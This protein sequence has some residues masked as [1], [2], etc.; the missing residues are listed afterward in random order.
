MA[1]FWD[2]L[3]SA[4][5]LGAYKTGPSTPAGAPLRQTVGGRA[6]QAATEVMS[7]VR[8]DVNRQ[9]MEALGRSDIAYAQRGTYRSG[10]ALEARQRLEEQA[11]R[12]I[13]AES[14]RT[15]LQRLGLVTQ[16]DLANMQLQASQQGQEAAM[17]GTIF[18]AAAPMLLSL[19]FPQTAP[20]T[21]GLGMAN[22]MQSMMSQQGSG[23]SP[24]LG[25][26]QY[27]RGMLQPY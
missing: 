5:S 1:G 10:S 26:S 24:Y 16:Y 7:A 3:L 8:A 6:E 23:M 22:F 15:A 27:G 9:L 19:I 21:T 18:E 12:D 25:S 4:A 2:S 13:S 14:A 17:W 11:L 20:L